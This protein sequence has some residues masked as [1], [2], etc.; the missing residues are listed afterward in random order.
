MTFAPLEAPPL[1]TADLPGIGGRIKSVPE[2]FEVEEIPAY[3]PC[4]TGEYLY[5]WV[6]KR[7]MGAEFFIR[8]IARRLGIPPGEVGT[9]GMKDRQALT[10][11]FV[12]VPD[13]GSERLAQLDGEGIRLL[14]V[15]RHGN[16]LK[17]GHLRGNRFRI[18]IRDVAA[19]AAERL[20][21]LLARLQAR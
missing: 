7:D 10:R 18:R 1:L 13:V 14:R 15:S 9:A 20:P 4:G 8:Q 2:D 17:P 19:A 5:L 12:S 21:P 11:Q 6:E 3:E 16:K